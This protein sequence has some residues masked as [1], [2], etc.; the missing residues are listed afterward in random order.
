MGLMKLLHGRLRDYGVLH[1]RR[2]DAWGGK[3]WQ[4][5]PGQYV[6][7]PPQERI[8]RRPRREDRQGCSGAE[9]VLPSGRG[10]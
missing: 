9:V 1:E 10:G 6:L 3:P 8:S 7:M 2:R 4:D 5:V